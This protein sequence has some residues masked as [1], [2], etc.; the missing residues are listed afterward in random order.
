MFSILRTSLFVLFVFVCTYMNGQNLEKMEF[1]FEAGSAKGINDVFSYNFQFSPGYKLTEN[2]TLGVGI[3]FVN[4]DN[5]TDLKNELIDNHYFQTGWHN[6]WKPYL[7]GKY[8]IS[9]NHRVNPFIKVDIGYAFFS[10][11]KK[12]SY[13]DEI[14]ND[15]V[16]IPFDIKGGI[17]STI[18]LGILKHSN[19]FG[20]A[21]T[22]SVFY[23][24]Q[25]VTYKYMSN[26]VRKNISSIGFNVGVIF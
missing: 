8:S 23:L 14:E 9:S 6:A 25:P 10:H 1:F 3:G 2:F 11:K 12:L 4:Y 17:N 26:S 13:V 7:H 15:Y 20:E 5:R 21:L 19:H 18:N 22:V 16:T 24:F